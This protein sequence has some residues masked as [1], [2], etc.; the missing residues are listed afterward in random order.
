MEQVLNADNDDT[1]PIDAAGENDDTD[2]GKQDDRSA[3]Q[4]E[5]DSTAPEPTSS[6]NQDVSHSEA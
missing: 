2:T 4:G 6:P 3:P 1:K 5:Y